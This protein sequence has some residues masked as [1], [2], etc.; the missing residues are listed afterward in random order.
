[1][2]LD[3]GARSPS[4]GL[5]T[6][7]SSVAL[8]ATAV[9]LIAAGLGLLVNIAAARL[10]GAEGFGVYSLAVIVGMTAALV[11]SLGFSPGAIRYVPAYA[12]ERDAA[13]LAGFR[14]ASLWATVIGCAALTAV[15]AAATTFMPDGEPMRD[16]FLFSLAIIAPFGITQTL[17]A[18][19]VAQ[20]RVVAAEF[21]QGV[22]RT[23]LTMAGLLALPAALGTDLNPG[24]ASLA[25]GIAGA[26]SAACLAALLWS[27]E[28]APRAAGPRPVY[29]LRSWI[30][31]GGA[32]MLVM[33]LAM[34]NERVDILMLGLLT[35]AR[36]V[37]V[38]AA[39][40]RLAGLALLAAA[41]LNSAYMPR[42]S[43]AYAEGDY[44]AVERLAV[45]C[46]RL[47]GIAALVFTLGA[48]AVGRPVLSLFGE[49][50]EAGWPALMLLGLAQF[51][52]AVGGASGLVLILGGRGGVTARGVGFG[53]VLNIALNAA[54]TPRFGGSGA[55]VATLVALTVTSL[56]YGLQCRWKLDLGVMLIS[57]PRAPVEAER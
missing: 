50:F 11:S 2:R 51:G 14:N 30:W 12:A 23:G 54:L 40:S 48:F 6:K 33:A 46:A 31:T 26:L 37:G 57:K 7:A 27:R 20:G 17:A 34:L 43:R 53:V 1:M 55:A 38:Y 45:E 9:K 21:V 56:Y 44:A 52:V 42:I 25:T 24:L 49:A 8:T 10:L 41:G 32:I 28:A 16:A 19:L 13:R 5:L 4:W 36:E 18:L 39:A 15:F 35:E 3:A 22:A 47:G 29:E